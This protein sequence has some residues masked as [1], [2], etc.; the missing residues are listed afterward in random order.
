MGWL[1]C[2]L[3]FGPRFWGQC[4]GSLTWPQ[5]KTILRACR[6]PRYLASPRRSP[7]FGQSYERFMHL[8]DEPSESSRTWPETF[9]RTRALKWHTDGSSRRGGRVRLNAHAWN[10]CRPERVSGVRIPPSP[11]SSPSYLH[12]LRKSRK[13]RAHQ[14]SF[15]NLR[16]AEN[17]NFGRQEPIEARFS[18]TRIWPVPFRAIG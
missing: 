11:P 1:I 16:A 12:S 10:A 5:S 17:S 2:K 13:S 14:R 3:D 8:P 7:S 9:W 4:R 6:T 18:P 15:F